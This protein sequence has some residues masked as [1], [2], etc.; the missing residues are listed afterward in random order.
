MYIMC[1]HALLNII[2]I[3]ADF[4]KNFQRFTNKKLIFD[5]NQN[6]I[7]K[8]ILIIYTK[9]TILIDLYF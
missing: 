5:T 6:I 4:T 2:G 3:N 7:L 9:C 8:H 1:L